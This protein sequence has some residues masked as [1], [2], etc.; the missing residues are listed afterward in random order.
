[1]E[2]KKQLLEIVEKVGRERQQYLKKL[3]QNI[4]ESIVKEMN[5]LEVKKNQNS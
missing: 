5:Y 4:P 3:F 1:M 2:S